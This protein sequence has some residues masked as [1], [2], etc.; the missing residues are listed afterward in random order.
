MNINFPV[1]D[2]QNLINAE[3]SVITTNKI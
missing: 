3:Y 1:A 2:D